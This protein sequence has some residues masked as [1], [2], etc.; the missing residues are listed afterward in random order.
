MQGK[1]QGEDAQVL[2][3][4][5]ALR[6]LSDSGSPDATRLL[7]SPEEA[8]WRCEDALKRLVECPGNGHH[9]TYN[10]LRGLVLVSL[11]EREHGVRALLRGLDFNAISTRFQLDS[12][13]ISTR[14][15]LDFNSISTRF[16]LDFNAIRTPF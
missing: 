15:Q 14:F 7:K 5:Y 11:D 3:W 2:L 1:E 9:I 4:Q 10:L 12:N 16:Q 6:L 8:M 13:A